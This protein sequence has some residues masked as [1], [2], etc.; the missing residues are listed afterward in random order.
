ME[1]EDQLPFTIES[2][3]R[4]RLSPTA[5]AWGQEW[6]LSLNELGKF[7]LN[8]DSLRKAGMIQRDGEN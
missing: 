2:P 3:T 8:Q 1:D 6:G 7:L 5:K 4:I